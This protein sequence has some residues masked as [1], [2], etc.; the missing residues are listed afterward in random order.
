M[1]RES[2]IT[3]VIDS[4]GRILKTRYK[5]LSEISSTTGYKEY[6]HPFTAYL[7]HQYLPVGHAIMTSDEKIHSSF[8]YQYGHG[9]FHKE[10]LGFLSSVHSVQSTC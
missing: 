7:T 4:Y 6:P 1:S 2:L 3:T 5:S 9:V 10:G 8:E